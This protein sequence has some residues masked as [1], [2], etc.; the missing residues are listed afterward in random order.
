MD[1]NEI[2]DKAEQHII[3]LVYPKVKVQKAYNYYN[4]RLDQEQFRYLEENYGIGNP[5]SMEFIPLIKKHVDALSNEHSEIPLIPTVSCKDKRTI[6][7]IMRTKQLK[8]KSETLREFRKM[9]RNSVLLGINGKINDKFISDKIQDVIENIDENFISEYEVTAQNLIKFI[10]ESRNIDLTNHRKK[11]AKDLFIS[12]QCYFRSLITP[13]G[14]GTMLE[15]YNPMNVFVEKNPNSNY[16]QDCNRMVVRHW[17]TYHEV[18]KRYGKYLNPETKKELEDTFREQARYVNSMLVRANVPDHNPFPI[19]QHVGDGVSITPGFPGDGD[20]YQRSYYNRFIPVYEV[21]WIESEKNGKNSFRLERYRAIRIGESIYINKGKDEKAI[22][23]IDD[24]DYVGL[25]MNGI[26]FCTRENKPFSLVLACAGLQDRYNIVHY[27]RESALSNSGTIGDYVDLAKLPVCLGEDWAERLE[28]LAA[29][30]KMGFHLFDSSQDGLPTVNTAFNGYD[31][32][33]KAQVVQA[34]NMIIQSIEETTSSVTGVSR[35][36]LANGIQQYDSVRNVQ[37]GVR[38]SFTITKD[39]YD[40]L[41]MVDRDILITQLDQAKIAYRNGLQGE[42]TLG[43]MKKTFVALPKYF[44]M[45]DFGVNIIPSSKIL[46]D[47]ETLKSAAA[48]FIRNGNYDTELVMEALTSDSLT[49]LKYNITKIYEKKKKEDNIIGKM[50]EQIQQLQ[51][52]LEDT[53]K[54]LEAA[55]KK[56]AQLDEKRLDIEAQK[57]KADTEVSM[58]KARTDR[59]FKRG[60]LENQKRRLELEISQL[61]DGNNYN[62]KIKDVNALN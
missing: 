53:S 45:T 44:T 51:Q 10:M 27:L 12:G 54:Q 38:N 8:I 3:E 55:N 7:D 56:I 41:D 25:S 20:E 29:Y 46:Q 50:N 61:S 32:T 14:H 22:R 6:S 34:F 35:E 9:F 47:M 16:V 18:L 40:Q 2:I 49:D 42:I 58:Y 60:T 15:T 33:L 59:D 52:Q 43:K 62:D 4:C 21:E 17:L 28:K 31:D 37:T 23:T 1:N 36:R 30:K 19:S 48:E 26:F 57:V 11:L 5:T 39:W 13:D 24:P